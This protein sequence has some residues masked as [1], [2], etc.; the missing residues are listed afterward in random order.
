MPEASIASITSPEQGAQQ[1]CSRT[2]FSP[3]GGMRTGRGV[4][5]MTGVLAGLEPG[6]T[7]EDADTGIFWQEAKGHESNLSY[8][9]M[10]I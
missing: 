2:F 4:S 6:I 7:W 9:D 8:K 10:F 3:L 5:V 1:E